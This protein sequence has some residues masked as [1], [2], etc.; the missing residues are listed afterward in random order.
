MAAPGTPSR[1][2]QNPIRRKEAKPII[3]HAASRVIQSPDSTRSCIAAT[4]NDMVPKKRGRSG[5]CAM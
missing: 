4:N 5:S 2:C 3:S 1:P